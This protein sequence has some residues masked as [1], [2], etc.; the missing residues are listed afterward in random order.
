VGAG[1]WRKSGRGGGCW[2]VE[3]VRGRERG[4][5]REA[6]LG[7][8]LLVELG[9]G[10]HEVVH[11]DFYCHVGVLELI[12]KSQRPS[13][14]PWKSLHG[15]LWRRI[16]GRV[17][18]DSSSRL[19]IILRICVTGVSCSVSRCQQH[20]TG[21]PARCTQGSALTV[22]EQQAHGHR[23]THTRPSMWERAHSE[24]PM[25]LVHEVLPPRGRACRC[26]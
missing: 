21:A 17:S 3:E 11:F 10:G 9:A 7:V 1:E 18:F 19:A 13:I 26:P 8:V 5:R 23:P 14:F 2:R 25:C 15:V 6:C 4:A 22:P 12:L 20:P 16:A 24:G